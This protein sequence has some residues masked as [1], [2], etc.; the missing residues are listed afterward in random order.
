ML[1]KLIIKIYFL[2]YG[3][4]RTNANYAQLENCINC[5]KHSI[6]QHTHWGDVNMNNQTNNI[7]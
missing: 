3:H 5:I 7:M 2:F 1:H 6:S 4:T